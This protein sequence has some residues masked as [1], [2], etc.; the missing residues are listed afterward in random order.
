MPTGFP[1]SLI[2]EDPRTAFLTF[3]NQQ[4]LPQGQNRFLRSQF[5]NINDQFQAQLGGQL[6]QGQIPTT[7]FFNEFLPQFNLQNFLG[8]FS[9]QSRGMGTSQFA[10]RTRFLGF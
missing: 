1:Q 9:P 10:P 5:G 3:L 4:G 8:G 7:S 2:D 6:T